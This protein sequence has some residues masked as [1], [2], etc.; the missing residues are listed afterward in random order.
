MATP[1]GSFCMDCH[2]NT[3]TMREF[4]M[5]DQDTWDSIIRLSE[6]DGMLCIGC[7]EVRLGRELEPADFDPDWRHLCPQPSS[8]LLKRRGY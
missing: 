6:Q 5:L 8:R 1:N 7:V 2:L 4:F 3:S